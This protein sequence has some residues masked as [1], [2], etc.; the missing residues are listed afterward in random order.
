M[1]REDHDFACNAHVYL[2]VCNVGGGV[3]YAW[4]DS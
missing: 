1:L 4:S 3:L 2:I